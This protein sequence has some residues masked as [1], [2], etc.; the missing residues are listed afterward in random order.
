M[1]VRNHLSTSLG[2]DLPA[3]L[4]FD[5][6][7]VPAL[8]AFVLSVLPLAG[9]STGLS[10]A[11]ATAGV[12]SPLPLSAWQSSNAALAPG[13]GVPSPEVRSTAA[14]EYLEAVC[15]VFAEAV[16]SEIGHAQPFAAAGLDSLAAV[17]VRN[18]LN[19]YVFEY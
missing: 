13:Q 15:T 8:T 9:I 14:R 3:T 10:T 18:S 5:Y 7:T 11:T 19:R 12:Q 1:E 17:E 2:I 4:V 6:P 16:G